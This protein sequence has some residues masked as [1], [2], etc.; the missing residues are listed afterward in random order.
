MDV[1]YRDICMD[2]EPFTCIPAWDVYSK[3]ELLV[4]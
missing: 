4:E 1:T 3:Q 2:Y